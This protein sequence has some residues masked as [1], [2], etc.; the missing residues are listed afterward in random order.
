IALLPVGSILFVGAGLLGAGELKDL[1]L[2]LFVGMLSGTYS[3]ICIAT[4][5]LADLK[6]REPQYKA[7]AKRVSLRAAGGRAARRAAA[8]AAPARGGAGGGGQGAAPPGGPGPRRPGPP[9]GPPP[10]GWA[11][12]SLIAWTTSKGLPRTRPPVGT[13]EPGH[14]N[15]SRPVPAR[16]PRGAPTPAAGAHASSRAAPARP[17][18]A[19][20]AK[21]GGGRRM[22]AGA[23]GGGRRAGGGGGGEGRGR[24]RR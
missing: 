15:R 6:E 9:R 20:G 21:R 3:S 24:G 1:A 7:L 8:R 10:Q 12:R 13:P 5:V 14:R 17:S 23:S 16:A 22:T 4:P 11:W 2:V 18:G 19:P